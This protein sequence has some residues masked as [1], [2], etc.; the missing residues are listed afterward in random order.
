MKNVI[1]IVVLLFAAIFGY[2]YYQNQKAESAAVATATKTNNSTNSMPTGSTDVSTNDGSNF[3]NIPL[4]YSEGFDEQ[5]TVTAPSAPSFSCDGRQHCSQ[6]T[7][8]SEATYF[9]QNCPNT[10]MDG[11]NDGIPCEQQWCN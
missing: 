11:N 1:L 2:K 9:V 8:C 4:T 7:S 5:L 10:K 3:D 6:M